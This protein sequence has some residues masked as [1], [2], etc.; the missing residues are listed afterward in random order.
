MGDGRSAAGETGGFST[1]NVQEAGIDEPDVV[2]T[3]GD[4]VFTVVGD[5]VHAVDV[6]SA[7]L[8]VVD[9]IELGEAWERELFLHDGRLLVI[10]ES[11]GT[12]STD[13]APA[14]APGAPVRAGDA[15]ETDAG[16]MTVLTEID[17]RDPSAMRVV[18]TVRAEGSY[19][20]ARRTGATARVVLTSRPALPA[21]TPAAI[22]A[23]R[24]RDWMPRGVITT[25]RTGMRRGRTL[26]ACSAVRRPAGFSGLGMLTVLTIDLDRGLP[27][28][29]SD[30][31]MTDAETVYSSPSSLYVATSRWT[32]PGIAGG[33]PPRS[34]STQI[35]R[36]EAGEDARTSYRATGEVRGR[37]L[38]QFA[39][40]EEDGHLRVAS[41]DAPMW[42]DGGEP[43]SESFVTVLDHTLAPVG[44]V[45]GLGRGERIYSVRFIG[46]V[47]YVVTFRET[48]P[49]YTIDLS[50][51]ATP[52]VA[53]ELKILGYSAYLH[54]LG[55]GLLLG[56]GQDAT[57]QGRVKGTQ[58]SV[59]DV[60]DVSR[61][62]RLHQR[63]L[64]AG[65]VSDVEFDHRAFLHWPASALAVL[66]IQTS[67]VETGRDFAGAIGFRVDR[68]GIE[69]LGRAEHLPRRRY[70]EPIIRALV[71]GDRVITVSSQ[72]LLTSS[73][74]EFA[75]LSWLPFPAA[76]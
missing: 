26:A 6:R 42:A 4:H 46:D 73:L 24:L 65:S 69:E 21:A 40:S 76:G 48:D 54:P 57:A 22:R 74:Q 8:E 7:A 49:L 44:R 1:T 61:P 43:A 37:L 71:A 63:T 5:A 50:N 62:E 27:W 17:A 41:T 58:L 29:D 19:L 70:P 23:S 30:A 18:R 47:G 35:H 39:L 14:D 75:S 64:A 33:A 34:I 11:F 3:D 51:P 67:G 52:R 16:P 45:R 13:P 55:D 25:R 56:V 72:G 59:F 15:P 9:R 36:F 10:S 53:G 20:S 60:S 28:V 66:P 68:S 32:D 2:K 12:V 38:N 31:V